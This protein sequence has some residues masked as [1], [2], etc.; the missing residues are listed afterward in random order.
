[1]ASGY[2]SDHDSK[3]PPSRQTSSE[4]VFMTP[5][6]SSPARSSRHS[7]PSTPGDP[8][9]SPPPLHSESSPDSVGDDAFSFDPRRLTPTLQANLVAEILN[10]R[11]EIDSKNRIIEDLETSLESSQNETQDLHTRLSA[12][13]SESRAAKRHVKTLETDTFTTL[14]E[15]AHERDQAKAETEM[16]RNKLE[17]T[18]KKA[19]HEGDA[20]DRTQ[21]LWRKDKDTWDAEKRT[22][23]R[24][25][26]VSETRLKAVLEEL[27]AQQAAARECFEAETEDN[28][29]DSGFA[30]EGDGVSLPPQSFS[31]SPKRT[32]SQRSRHERNHSGGSMRSFRRNRASAL[33]VGSELQQ[34]LSGPSLADEL[35]LDEEEEE[36]EEEV[37]L[38]DGLDS[39]DYSENE[40]RARRALELRQSQLPDGKARKMLGLETDGK[41]STS[42]HESDAKEAKQSVDNVSI[43]RQSLDKSAKPSRKVVQSKH[44]YVDTG[45]QPSPPPSPKV[46]P[47]VMAA[48]R[49]SG[50]IV[51]AMVNLE[52][53]QREK[54]ISDQQTGSKIPHHKTRPMVSS[55]C[56]TLNHPPSPPETPTILFHQRPT[57]SSPSTN[58]RPKMMSIST[59]TTQIKISE[60]S[61]L[62]VPPTPT[63][64]P[65]P[66]AIAVPQITIEPPGSCP[67]SPTRGV[68]SPGTKSVYSQTSPDI[69]PD[70]CSRAM[71]T[72]PIMVTRLGKL[73][74][75][76]LSSSISSQLE[77]KPVLA[78]PFEEKGKSPLRATQAAQS[79]LKSMRHKSVEATEDK[80]PGHNDD[81]PLTTESTDGIRRPF[82]SSS[83]FA[84]FDEE[85]V[86]DESDDEQR[87]ESSTYSRMTK[88]HSRLAK[89]PTPVPEEREPPSRPRSSCS[90][91]VEKSPSIR[92]QSSLRRSNMSPTRVS[93]GLGE[94]SKLASA[95][96]PY[97]VPIRSSSRKLPLS[98]SEGSQS[99]PIRNNMLANRR[100]RKDSTA[101][102]D[103]LRKV[104]SA[105]VMRRS[106]RFPGRS[107]PPPKTSLTSPTGSQTQSPVGQ[108][109]VSTPKQSRAEGRGHRSQ[110]S[111]STANH[112]NNHTPE[113]PSQSI[114]VVDAIAITMVGEWMRKYVRGRKSFGVSDSVS[115]GFGK[116]DGT[117]NTGINGLRHKR[118]VW[119]S[120]YERSILWSSKQPTN[121]TGLMGKPGRKLVV[122]SV[123]DVKDDGPPPKGSGSQPVFN[124]S[125]LVL[126]PARALKFTAMSAER[127][128]IWLTA[129]S[130]L[131]HSSQSLPNL[132][133]LPTP[134]PQ[135]PIKKKLGPLST[136]KS[137]SSIRA[138]KEAQAAKDKLVPTQAES[139]PDGKVTQSPASESFSPPAIPRYH[140][141]KRSVSSPR[142]TTFRPPMPH[143]F[144]GRSFSSNHASANIPPVPAIPKAIQSTRSPSAGTSDIQSPTSPNVPPSV[145]SSIYN[146]STS[147]RTSA[148]SGA[149]T[150]STQRRE[151]FDA[152][153]GMMRMEAFVDSTQRSDSKHSD[154]GLTDLRGAAN[155]RHSAGKQMR[156]SSGNQKAASITT[157][158]G[159][160]S[161]STP[162]PINNEHAGGFF[163]EF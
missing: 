140:G 45:V 105:A 103:S 139:P 151:F 65:P 3:A 27:A 147:R 40:L 32:L 71:Q 138:T 93:Q 56:Q 62:D 108:D 152:V 9:A 160:G 68:L 121:N 126:T 25:I 42:E 15:L 1:M 61:N 6:P 97:P 89:P 76:L 87:R 155:S 64:A 113:S 84:G 150:H 22:L 63:R 96:P 79:A 83:L 49:Y 95:R 12:S 30:M 57:A 100:S 29:R 144:F 39:E 41:Q 21:D 101:R 70:V 98:R 44:E 116:D 141:R 156:S 110:H 73:P 72:E 16:L 131:A 148:S 146:P 17:D 11:R 107:P 114:S 91:K 106:D 67:T 10:L 119:I 132:G 99:P 153:A 51:S 38:D 47:Q 135:E 81:G 24:R 54:P 59:Q 75:H 52:T 102:Q 149:A 86:A 104:R 88:Y 112:D 111:R 66:T 28:I 78:K 94:S 35:A 117:G 26:H 80:Y 120:P 46:A 159:P 162:D 18:R 23:E 50:H 92:R 20:S 82:R 158:R 2:S 142:Q 85:A 33:T 5:Q 145:P 58:S 14:E 36:E 123:L 133:Q 37:D 136:S 48:A 129:L 127:H 115:P 143:N 137:S 154:G 53:N 31:N 122:Q 125:I 163:K 60:T 55:S 109:R 130:F 134:A 7:T 34:K 77:T 4:T 90:V 74:A 118:W 8:D 161:A 13:Q 157:N 124:R 19:R 128:Y 69:L 43:G